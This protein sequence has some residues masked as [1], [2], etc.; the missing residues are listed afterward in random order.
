MVLRAV[1]TRR[2]VL[3]SFAV[4]ASISL[5]ASASN[6][7]SS[8]GN[9]SSS[10]SEASSVR[11]VTSMN[12][13]DVLALLF[14][15][16]GLTISSAGGIGGG[17]IIV[18]AL[19]IIMG[20]DVKTAT[21]ISNMGILGGALANTIFN[22]AKR[23]PSLDRPLI[24]ADLSLMT[25]PLVIGGAVVGAVLAN[26][27]PSYIIS[28]LFVPLLATS[29][30]RM[31]FKGLQLQRKE[32]A[33][34]KVQQLDQ[35]AHT[36]VTDFLC[37]MTPSDRDADCNQRTPVDGEK[38]RS[39]S[40]CSSE[41][42]LRVRGVQG[43][44]PEQDEKAE[45]V[46][47][48]LERECHFPWLKHAA[49]LLCYLVVVAASIADALVSCGGVAYW[50]LLVVEIPVVSVFAVLAS[51]YLYRQDQRKQQI[52]YPFAVGDV[53]WTKK[54][55]T[56]FPIGSA[57]AGIVAGLFG[58]GGVIITGPIMIELGVI[59]E[60]LAGAAALLV[61]YS[62]AAATAKY[63]VFDMIQWDW[64]FLVCALAFAVTSCSQ[65]VIVRYVRR[66][67]KQSIIVLCIASTILLAMVLMTYEAVRDT[68]DDLGAP[69]V[70]DVCD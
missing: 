57:A 61:L 4:C 20:M 59:P 62:S 39:L 68:I 51:I 23:H 24:D 44:L 31:L 48:L 47:L 7:T 6:S 40:S 14:M 55:V 65:V 64:A 66:T 67:G 69:F 43:G 29:G 13:Y 54:V 9:D 26:L 34:R 19:V 18:P 46:A 11:G 2:L 12:V 42:S 3:L 8:D 56:L 38:L 28:I 50:A 17:G 5:V 16:C 30:F 33:V 1:T 37:V 10:S 35:Q 60:V 27:M 52:D 53:R 15:A 21:P 49:I 41:V 63:A 36:Q 58:I 25:T 22:M 70:V 45:A 32:R